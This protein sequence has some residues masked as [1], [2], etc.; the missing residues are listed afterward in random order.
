MENKK[1]AFNKQTA[2]LDKV[3]VQEK[4]NEKDNFKIDFPSEGEV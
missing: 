4:L 2:R 1:K 3:G